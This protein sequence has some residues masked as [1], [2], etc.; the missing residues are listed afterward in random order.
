VPAITVVDEGID[1][2]VVMEEK[3]NEYVCS[4]CKNTND[5]VAPVQDTP[6]LLRSSA[7]ILHEIIASMQTNMDNPLN[8]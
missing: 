3:N 7:D 2:V 4:K 1:S 8:A 5:V 6:D